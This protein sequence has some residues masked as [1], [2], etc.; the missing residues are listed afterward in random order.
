MRRW[1]RAVA[2]LVVALGMGAASGC[3][4]Y[5]YIDINT[6]I[7][8]VS[9]TR[10]DAFR[11][12]VC[13]VVVSGTDNDN[14]YITTNCPPSP[15]GADPYNIGTFEF[16][17]LADSGSDTFDIKAYERQMEVPDCLLGEGMVTVTLSSAMTLTGDLK[18][19]KTANGC[20]NGPG[21]Q[22][23]DANFDFGP[24]SGG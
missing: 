18:I 16:H 17:T 1:E 9:F 6:T 10:S 13:H 22:Q 24:G 2:L 14:F 19:K 11:I 23:Q 3:K 21:P 15:T 7:D 5:K 4:S 8:S 20:M 12:S